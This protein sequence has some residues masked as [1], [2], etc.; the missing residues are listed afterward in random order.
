MTKSQGFGLKKLDIDT[1]AAKSNLDKEAKDIEAKNSES[2][3]SLVKEIGDLNK[4]IKDIKSTV[5]GIAVKK[6]AA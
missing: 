5:D 1:K 4:T 6:G 2:L 3:N